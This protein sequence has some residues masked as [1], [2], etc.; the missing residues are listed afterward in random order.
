METTLHSK[1]FSPNSFSLQSKTPNKLGIRSVGL[2]EMLALVQE[3]GDYEMSLRLLLRAGDIIQHYMAA[4]FNQS[5][6][7]MKE[8]KVLC[9]AGGDKWG[10]L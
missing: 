4:Y 6:L 5:K 1:M 8:I 7:G 3:E 10:K 9:R 2:P